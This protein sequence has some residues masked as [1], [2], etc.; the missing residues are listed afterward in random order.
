[1]KESHSKLEHNKDKVFPVPV[2][3]EKYTFYPSLLR[4]LNNTF[5][6]SIY[7]L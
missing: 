1:M 6:R 5:T 4:F 3:E 7:D 2:S